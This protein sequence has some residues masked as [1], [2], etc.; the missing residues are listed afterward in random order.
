M[1]TTRLDILSHRKK[2]LTDEEIMNLPGWADALD[3]LITNFIKDKGRGPD[4]LQIK[5]LSEI[6]M[7]RFRYLGYL[8]FNRKV[9]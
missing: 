9:A 7:E 2:E 3:E 8:K 4:H 5:Y 1:M 6:L